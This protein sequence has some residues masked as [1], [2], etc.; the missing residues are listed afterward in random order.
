VELGD[1]SK[2]KLNTA[3]YL[4]YFVDGFVHVARDGFTKSRM[5]SNSKSQIDDAFR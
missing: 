3:L 5:V 1:R 2:D 4:L